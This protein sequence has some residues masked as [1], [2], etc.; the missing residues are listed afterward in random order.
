GKTELV[1]VWSLLRRGLRMHPFSQEEYRGRNKG[2]R[3]LMAQRGVDTLLIFDAANIYYLTGY[4]GYSD[5]N[6]QLA[7]VRQDEEDPW[8][9]LREMDVVA[10]EASSYLPHSRILSYP[11][12]YIGSSQSTPWQPI[13]DFIRERSRAS[14]GRIGVELSAKVLGVKGHAALSKSLGV[15]EFI[16]AD[17]MVLTLKVIKSP[18]EL[19]YMEQAGKIADRA[20]QAG[21][22]A[23]SVGARQCDVAADLSHALHAGTPEFPGSSPQQFSMNV[24]SPA[25]AVHLAWTDERYK[26]GCQTIFEIGAFRHRYCSALSRTIF[27]GE[28]SARERHVHQACLDGFLAAF[29][30][31]R[32]GVTCSDVNRAFRR[33]FEP[34]GVR[35]TSKI[36]YSLG[37]DWIDGGLNMQEGDES[38][39]QA[40]MTFHLIIGIFEKTDGYLLSE[41]VRVTDD[42]AKS[43][44]NMSRDLLVNY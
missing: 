36:G 6:P 32:P 11:E 5:Y 34:R 22:L 8:L 37:I 3:Q 21:R 1:A 18:A 13:S 29:D 26:T 38:V 41:T 42:G 23:I 14:R 9:I 30:A 16:D 33:E 4:A 35:K 7:L 10:S 43:L 27:L 24:G 44:S 25:N 2:L 15:S 20:M 39:V 28:P 31:I 19:T 40:N 17:G 12:K